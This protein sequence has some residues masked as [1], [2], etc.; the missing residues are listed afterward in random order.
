MILKAEKKRNFAHTYMQILAEHVP[1]TI[2]DHHLLR[3]LEYKEYLRPIY[4]AAEKMET[5]F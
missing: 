5:E 3:T 1:L 4:A 2:V